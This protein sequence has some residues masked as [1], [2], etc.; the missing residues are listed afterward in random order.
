MKLLNLYDKKKKQITSFF[1]LLIFLSLANMYSCKDFL[2]IDN[3]FS[4]E[5]KLDSVFAQT[6]YVK[7]YMWGAADMFPDEGNLLQDQHTP[8]PLAT[9]EAFTSF[10]TLHNYNGM[11]FVLGEIT[12]GS[13]HS[14]GSVWSNMYRVIRKC[15]TILAR[16]D[17]PVDMTT[18]ERFEIIGYTRFM[19]AYAY[20]NILVDFGPPILLGD[21]ILES[22][23]TL[24]DYDRP[25][26]TYDEAVEYICS[27]LETAAEYLPLTV[28]LMEFGLPTKGAAY[29][30]LARLRLIHASPLYN[31]GDAARTYFGNWK[32]STDGA[33]YVSQTYDEKRWALAAAAAKRVMDLQS[34]GAPMYKLHTVQADSDTPKLPEG[35]TSDPDY[36]KDWPDGAAGIDPFR[37]YSEMFNGEAV[38]PVNPEYV[39]GRRSNA[40]RE[41]TRMSFPQRLDGWNGMSVP[42]KVVDAYAMVDGRPISSSSQ[43]YPYS[44]A[45]FSNGVKTFSGYRLNA[46]V[47][48]MYVNR[49]ARFYASVGFSECYWP[50]TSSTSSGYYNQT[51]TYYYDS[52]NGKGGVTSAQDHPITGYVIKKFIHPTDAWGGTNNRRMDKGFP[53]IRYAEILLSYAEALNN[54]TS[55][56]SI[57]VNGQTQVLERNMDEIKKAFNQVRHRAGLPGLTGTE[58][59]KTVQQLIQQERFVEFLFENRRYYDVRRWGIYEEV[60]SEPIKGMNVE[61]T[62]EVFYI[63]VIPNTS[64]IG[65]RIV[66][67]RLNWLPIPLNEVRLLPSLDQNPGWG[68]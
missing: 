11:R 54:L 24:A 26:S 40:I 22:N 42:Q 36:Y 56:H 31:G 18:T 33:Q 13:M 35:V 34:A 12:E 44:E 46:G 58:D 10:L 32:R 27:E 23:A 48:N 20:Y 30:L 59:A 38:I 47:S 51:I 53:I 1:L 19:R 3:Y 9:D 28:S 37:S 17:E 8:G 57:E 50:M 43:G 64:R 65:A 2:S 61:G 15:N 29:G 63:R 52:P 14:F 60:E 25:R 16:I 21:E 55:S 39:W 68:E 62:K 66:N 67:K 7:A 6:R 45:G 4:D 41:N 49:E 5:L